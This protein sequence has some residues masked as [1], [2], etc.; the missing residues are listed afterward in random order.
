MGVTWSSYG[1]LSWWSRAGAGWLVARQRRSCCC[2]FNCGHELLLLSKALGT[3][4][5][6]LSLRNSHEFYWL[7]WRTVSAVHLTV[8]CR[9]G[10][11]A[12]HNWLLSSQQCFFVSP[13]GGVLLPAADPEI[14]AMRRS[15]LLPTWYHAAVTINTSSLPL[16]PWL[17]FRA[18][19][20]Q[21]LHPISSTVSYKFVT[22]GL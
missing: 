8:R 5:T 4:V 3:A 6:I 21:I 19:T 2:C 16:N 20:F 18:Y 11:I 13:W 9:G 1:A 10:Q 22:V 14:G 7:S 17:G 12:W 15:I